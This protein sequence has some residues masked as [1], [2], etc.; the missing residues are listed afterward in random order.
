MKSI[1]I[2]GATGLTGGHLL[3]LSLED[4]SVA[5]VTVLVRKPL[6]KTHPKLKTVITDFDH[7]SDVESH[8]R[9]DM[10]FCCL[11]TTIK[12]AGSRENFRKV[13]FD[14]PLE[15]AKLAKR[16]GAGFSVIT[17]IGA[18]AS[19]TF[20]Y[21]RTKGE[22]ENELKKVG[23]HTL[24]IHRPAGIMGERKEER[25]LESV[26]NTALGF[27][28]P[29]LVG[30]LKMIRPVKAKTIASCMLKEGLTASEENKIFE[31][32]AYQDNGI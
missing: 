12:K 15:C 16:Q 13:D 32:T 21:S 1:L 22:L 14:Y 7:L 27:L 11:G 20:F 25:P 6:G 30:P 3:N 2:A 8:F 5:S 23:L 4:E 29:F 28:S 24:H 9:V 18:D 31:S 19:S 26:A 10:V 17:A